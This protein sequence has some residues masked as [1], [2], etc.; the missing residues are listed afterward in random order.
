MR[1]IKLIRNKIVILQFSEDL[2]FDAVWNQIVNLPIWFP[3]AILFFLFVIVRLIA[4]LGKFLCQE[5]KIA[6]NI[7]E[8]SNPAEL[9]INIHA[10]IKRM[11]I[12]VDEFSAEPNGTVTTSLGNS[13]TKQNTNTCSRISSTE[14]MPMFMESHTLSNECVPM[15][16]ACDTEI[17]TTMRLKNGA[18]DAYKYLCSCVRDN[19]ILARP[20]INS[21][22][23][24][25]IRP[26]ICKK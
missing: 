23:R 8:M 14:K 10:P 19:K 13:F 9:S 5:E 1:L 16:N 18:S 3:L 21:S 20:S 17:P 2:D 6:V 12:N 24:P 26:T 11:S 22:C 4:I 15:A 7:P 25:S